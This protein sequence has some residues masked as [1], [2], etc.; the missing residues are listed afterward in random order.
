M[1]RD[2]EAEDSPTRIFEAEHLA[3]ASSDTLSPIL[4]A[5]G[6]K[7]WRQQVIARRGNVLLEEI[8]GHYYLQAFWRLTGSK[9]PVSFIAATGAN[10]I[11]QLAFQ[12]MGWGLEFA[13]VVDDD[14]RGRG[15]FNDL[16]RDLF[17]N[18]DAKARTHMLKIPDCNGIEDL[19]SAHD[20]TK[21]VCTDYVTRGQQT[22]SAWLKTNGTSKPL[23]AYGFLQK[24]LQGQLKLDDLEATTQQ[25]ITNLASAIESLT[26][27][28]DR[29]M[30]DAPR[31]PF[32]RKASAHPTCDR[33]LS[34]GGQGL[35]EG[36]FRT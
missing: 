32:G 13:V 9:V 24:V 4:G 8:S 6:T 14:S 16:K 11:P 29:A 28:K 12:F 17:V 33:G 20:F 2:G 23:I 34:R 19:F 7:L 10:K 27:G 1:Q 21:F 35:Q 5:M 36:T 3:A 22:V 31:L 15:V 18:D 26:P 30:K 25:R